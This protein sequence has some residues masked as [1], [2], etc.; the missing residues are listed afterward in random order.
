MSEKSNPAGES[1]TTVQNLFR[2]AQKL[3]DDVQELRIGV[4][5]QPRLLMLHERMTELRNAL[6]L[7]AKA[8]SR[9]RAYARSKQNENL[10]ESARKALSAIA[11]FFPVLRSL[12]EKV[13]Q[14]IVLAEHV[15]P[16]N[17]FY[18]DLTACKKELRS[19]LAPI[20]DDA[21]GRAETRLFEISAT[22]ERLKGKRNTLNAELPPKIESYC[23]LFDSIFSA[24]ER[25]D[26]LASASAEIATALRAPAYQAVAASYIFDREFY[27]A[28]LPE[29]A[30]DAVKHYLT[31][32]PDGLY[33]PNKFFSDRHY[34]AAYPEVRRLRYNALE[35]FM[36]YG[37]ALRYN[38]CP[39]FNTR[40]YL[41]NNDDV[42]D[43][44]VSAFQHFLFHG[45]VEERPP[46]GKATAFFNDRYLEASAGRAAKLVFVG[47]PEKTEDNKA[48]A[49]LR[50]LCEAREDANVGSVETW[51]DGDAGG[52]DGY[53]VCGE[54]LRRAP[55]DFFRSLKESGAAL[56]YFGSEPQEDLAGLLRDNILP[57]EKIR[58]FTNNY[59]R[60]IRWQESETPLRLHYYP[61][62]DATVAISVVRALLETLQTGRNAVRKF[63]QSLANAPAIS[64]VSI[65]YKKSKEMC[66]FLESLNRQ[67]IAREYEVILVNDATPDDAVQVVERWL[68]EKRQAG[69]LNRFMHVRILNN[70]SNLGNCLSRNKG[71]EASKAEIVLVAD[72]DVVFGPSCLTEHRWA[73][74][75]GDCDAVIGFFHF[76]MDYD[77]IFTWAAACEVNPHIVRR[78]VDFSAQHLFFPN[79]MD[80][81]HNF[82][83]RNTSFKKSVLREEYFDPDFSYTTHPDSGYGEEDHELSTRLYIEGHRVRFAESAVAI[84]TRHQDNSYSTDKMLAN[85]RNWNRLI[86]K[87]P[88]LMLIDRQYYQWRTLNL[89]GKTKARPDSKE[90]IEGTTRYSDPNRVNIVIKKSKTLNIV[91]YRWHAAHQYELFK[92]SHNFT[93]VTNSGTVMCDHWDYGQRPLPRNVR[94]MPLHDV[95]VQEYDFAI[96][97]FDENVLHPEQCNGAL[98]PDW[99]KT[100]FN[101]LAL[102][103]GMPRAAICHD[104]PGRYGDFLKDGEAVPERGGKTSAE[105][106]AAFLNLLNDIHVVC[107]SY[108]ARTEWGFQKSSVIWLGFSPYEFPPGTHEKGC[109]T[110]PENAFG[111]PEKERLRRL[112]TSLKGICPLEYAVP[113]PPHPGYAVG[114]QDWAI[115]GLQNYTRYLGE[116]AVYLT[117]A[118]SDSMPHS[119]AEAMLTGA[120]PVAMRNED[121]SLLI[122]HGINGFIADS[123]EEMV[124][125]VTWLMKNKDARKKIGENARQTAMDIFN[126][127]RY[128]ASWSELIGNFH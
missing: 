48:W 79:P 96:L 98:T 6:R 118:L 53:F 62:D 60:F 43:A 72:G 83:T 108:Q 3:L 18:A 5:P 13:S 101:M 94:F 27:L 24:L 14:D 75:F 82:V 69:L 93:L 127:D 91:T 9:K 7:G 102:T 105:E 11:G 46:S 36:R 122:R 85:L 37:D 50:E 55:G 117:P 15:L 90:F 87:H 17:Q 54:S 84:H 121:V 124:E 41:E 66:A 73:Y 65:I 61:F 125:H 51:P 107:D 25:Y 128:L 126:I 78:R 71:I 29:A 39:E 89:L 16:Y 26:Y 45:L 109:L 21:T 35:H 64:V 30:P 116:F 49:I 120:V 22:V 77:F 123:V 106:R 92:L 119:R 47:E 70:E 113:P 31:K 115:A 68:E 81:I 97:P 110:L 10:A 1:A 88:D 114:T 63:V 104:T 100:F 74:R 8:V 56:I 38:P 112:E 28:Q 111:T 80:G 32:N 67:D 34:L 99:G 40:F 52:A 58:A 103:R 19:L 42:L 4:L 76:N 23:K 44:R 2:K 57:L 95:N 86:A 20:K 33:A 59:E 12:K